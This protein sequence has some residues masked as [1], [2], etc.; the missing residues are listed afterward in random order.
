MEDVRTLVASGDPWL[1]HLVGESCK[2]NQG[3]KGHH[4]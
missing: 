2:D 1:H 3:W 4:F